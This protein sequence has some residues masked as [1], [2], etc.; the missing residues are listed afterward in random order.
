[1]WLAVL[2]M[3]PLVAAGDVNR[4]WY[5]LPLIVSVSLVYSATRHEDMKHILLHAL[6]FGAWVVGFMAVV[7]V[8]LYFVSRD[9]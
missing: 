5:A 1:M 7:F 2:S 8:L 4:F 3:I 6:R 9:L